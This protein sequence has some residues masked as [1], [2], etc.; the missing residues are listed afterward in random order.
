[1]KVEQL[2]AKGE[3]GVAVGATPASHGAL[4]SCWQIY[5]WVVRAS[6]L[7]IIPV[8]AGHCLRPFSIPGRSRA[9]HPPV[10]E[11]KYN[12]NSVSLRWF[13]ARSL[14]EQK[15]MGENSGGRD[16]VAKSDS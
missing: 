4:A 8:G 15:G 9:L 3:S 13:G 11:G 10:L 16:A 7:V 5:P 1:M 6:P 12:C 2:A 14:G